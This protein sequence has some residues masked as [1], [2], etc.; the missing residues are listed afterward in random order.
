MTPIIAFIPG[1]S[2]EAP[3]QPWKA[4]V[5]QV[6][7]AP[8]SKSC[9]LCLLV[10]VGLVRALNLAQPGKS[11]PCSGRQLRLLHCVLPRTRLLPVSPGLGENICVWP[12]W[13]CF[14]CHLFLLRFCSWDRGSEMLGASIRNMPAALF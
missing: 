8:H 4:A 12:F 14:L 6:L 2:P 11:E 1:P 3:A 10:Q 5:T 13:R 7:R 9:Q